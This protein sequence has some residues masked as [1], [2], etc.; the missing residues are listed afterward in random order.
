MTPEAARRCRWRWLPAAVV[1][2]TAAAVSP[3]AAQPLVVPYLPQSEDLCGG[4]AAAMVMRY[5][6]D[7][8]VYPDAFQSLVDRHAGGIRT[9][10]LTSDL[11]RRGWTTIAGAGDTT[12][13][14]KE[15]HRGRPVIALVQDSPGRFHYVVVVGLDDGRV[16]LH[17]P[18]RLPD[19]VLPVARFDE[20]WRQSNRWMLILL[21]RI[22]PGNAAGQDVSPVNTRAPD[23]ADVPTVTP[24]GDSAC[25]R[26]VEAGVA[27]ATA[28]RAAARTLLGRATA[29]CPRDPAAWREL[30]GLDV[31]EADWSAAAVHARQAVTLA[32]GDAYAWR[33]LATAE[34]VRHDD[35]AAL[36]A[37]NRIGE[38]LVNLVDVE[39]LEH[40]RYG[41]V[42]DA[43]GVPLKS[44]LTPDAIRLGERRLHDVPSVAAA[45]LTFHPVEDGR[46]HVDASVLER[47]RLPWGYAAWIGMGFE[48]AVDRQIS[49]QFSSLT[50]GGELTGVTWRW[51]EHRPMVAGFFAAPA[52]MFGGGTIRL[53]ALH[54]TQTFG[55]DARAET[56]TRVAMS[57]GRWM[58][59]RTRMTATAGVERWT[60]RP[61]DLSVTYAMQ[62]LRFDDRLRFAGGLSQAFGASPFTIIDASAALRSRAANQGFVLFGLGAYSAASTRS[63]MSVWAGADTGQAR[64]VLLRAHPLLDDGTI[65]GGVFGRSLASGTIEAQ[66]WRMLRLM[67]GRF[68]PAVFVDLARASRGLGGAVSP[69]QADAGAGLRIAIAGAGVMRI[70]AAR[71]LRDGHMALSAGWDVRWR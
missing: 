22:D 44:Q 24:G 64:D 25:A 26:L 70:D 43:I 17:D 18:A 55:G 34:Y 29:E 40:T 23:S 36:A 38:P 63:P 3:A 33:I 66:Q 59:D 16:T 54:E 21:P 69:V 52:P 10:D 68:A 1:F 65:T 4:A 9:A 28:D 35:L 30:A 15:L 31:L 2:A 46:V 41:I 50:G 13:I 58:T 27:R 37:W 67:P 14:V 45:R 6:G 42:A 71:G 60:D 8:N 49:A 62:H 32:P 11:Q 19:R 48:A 53:D 56:R 51:W 20:Q 39:G 47:D 12:E 7:S 5:W 57:L 61:A